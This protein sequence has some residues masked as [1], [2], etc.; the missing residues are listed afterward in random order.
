VLD[1]PVSGVEF[2]V[3]VVSSFLGSLL[4]ASAGVGGGSLLLVVMASILPPAVLRKV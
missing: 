3:L 4:S 2:I 1:L